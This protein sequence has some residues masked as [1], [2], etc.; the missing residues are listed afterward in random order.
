MFSSE[1]NQLMRARYQPF[2]WPNVACFILPVFFYTRH[3][4]TE[5]HLVI[6]LNVLCCCT[7]SADVFMLCNSQ[8]I[9][10]PCDEA[11]F[12]AGAC[13]DALRSGR[14]TL[15]L[16]VDLFSLPQSAK[17]PKQMWCSS[18]TAPGVSARRASPKSCTL[19]LAWSLPSTSSDRQ[20]CRFVGN[21][22]ARSD[23]K[24]QWFCFYLHGKK[25]M[26]KQIQS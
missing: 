16:H 8:T 17:V 1:G 12:S 25:T 9:N 7:L 14:W 18:S 20:E 24:L 10:M 26:G 5:P 15:K 4:S 6:F 3:Y 13:D 11:I 21:T 22:V 19:S 2:W 23:I